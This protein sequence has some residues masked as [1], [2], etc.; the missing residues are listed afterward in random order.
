MKDIILLDSDS[1]DS[2]FCNEKYVSNIRPSKEPLLM[3]TNGGGQL[4]S[5]YKCDVP[6]I[7]EAWFDSSSITN[8]ISLADMAKAHRVTM[9]TDKEKTLNVHTKNQV[10]KFKQFPNGLYGMNP[11]APESLLKKVS[12]ACYTLRC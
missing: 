2:I 6:Y 1:T 3:G 8:I 9:D 4:V 12:I 5:K 7:G 11:E 10:L